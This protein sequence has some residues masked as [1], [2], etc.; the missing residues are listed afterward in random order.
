MVICEIGKQ[1]GTIITKSN[2]SKS[3]EWK[4]F[5]DFFVL[6]LILVRVLKSGEMIHPFKLKIYF[7]AEDPSIHYAFGLNEDMTGITS[8]AY[9]TAMNGVEIACFLS[10]PKDCPNLQSAL[11]S[12]MSSKSKSH[13]GAIKME[14]R[15]KIGVFQF[16]PLDIF[17]NGDRH[18]EKESLK[19][20]KSSMNTSIVFSIMSW[21]IAI[22]H[23]W[24]VPGQWNL[25]ITR[26]AIEETIVLVSRESFEH[27]IHEGQWEMVFSGGFSHFT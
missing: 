20:E 3:F 14:P 19:T 26:E 16:T 18:V 11:Q 25:K 23:R 22:I 21:K 12:H 13:S 8:K 2:R 15:D 27:L 24:N 9:T 4:C 10:L 7:I 17:S 1:W 5:R 6:E